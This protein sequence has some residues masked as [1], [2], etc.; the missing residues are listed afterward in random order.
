MASCQK[1]FQKVQKNEF[2]YCWNGTAHL[3]DSDLV[4]EVTDE[5]LA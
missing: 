3:V 2:V 4:N 5:V 1:R